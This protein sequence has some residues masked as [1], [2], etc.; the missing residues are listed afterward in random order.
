MKCKYPGS[1]CISRNGTECAFSDAEICQPMDEKGKRYQIRE[2]VE[3]GT[4]MT[5]K[6]PPVVDT[7]HCT[8]CKAM[9]MCQAIVNISPNGWN[10]WGY[11]G[12]KPCPGVL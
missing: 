5:A 6:V 12:Q 10:P 7:T 8:S 11:A 2:W 4:K 3:D 9:R 1:Q